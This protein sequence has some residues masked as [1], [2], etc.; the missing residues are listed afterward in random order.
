MTLQISNSSID[1]YRVQALRRP[2]MEDQA[3]WLQPAA[4]RAW[5]VPG[6]AGIADRLADRLAFFS[7]GSVGS[8]T[9]FF[10]DKG[11][12]V[13][14]TWIDEPAANHGLILG[15]EQAA[16]GFSAISSESPTA[17]LRPRLS[18]SYTLPAP[19]HPSRPLP[20]LHLLRER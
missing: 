4:S 10:N 7:P 17:A 6:A 13:L 5:S 3:T 14:Q 12:E 16:D 11:R 18:L 20:W 9:F 2:W 8:H 15:N 19:P 1:S